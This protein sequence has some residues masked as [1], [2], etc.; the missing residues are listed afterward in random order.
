MV[1][2]ELCSALK[3]VYAIAM[4]WCRGLQKKGGVKQ[5]DNLKALV[6]AK[7]VT[8]MRSIIKSNR[9]ALST[10]MGLAGVGDLYVTSRSGRNETFG[11]LLGKGITCHEALRE[12]ER[13]GR[14]VVEGYRTV[15]L[16]K[17]FIKVS[18]PLFSSIH[19][20]LNGKK[21]ADDALKELLTKL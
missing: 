1:G 15:F 7:A 20:V 13:H 19:A 11:Y 3:N 8:E 14:G 5:L 21:G 12:M 18:A 16:A 10:V 17:A 6:F 2:L 9:G 4:G